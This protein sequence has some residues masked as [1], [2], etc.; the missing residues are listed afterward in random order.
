MADL[1]RI[2]QAVALHQAGRLAEAGP[3]YA[4]LL[5]S[6]PKDPQ[7]WYLYGALLT[8][9]SR[10]AEAVAP[11]ERA[12]GLRADY[13]EAWSA[14]ARCFNELRRY[15]EAE[16]ALRKVLR[17]QPRDLGAHCNLA[18]VLQTVG[19]YEASLKVYDEALAL[20]PGH[21]DAV[22]GK[23]E[24]LLTMGRYQESF[25]L[26]E[27]LVEGGTDHPEVVRVYAEAS[28]RM[29]CP[30]A[31]LEQARAVLA[32][33]DISE[34]HRRKLAFAAGRLADRL[35]HYDEAFG[36]FQ[37]GNRLDPNY[38]AEDTYLD[39][40]RRT[41]DWWDA[42]RHRSLPA[43]GIDSD[44]P[45]FIVGMPRSG[46]SLTEQVLDSH[47]QV[48]GAGELDDFGDLAFGLAWEIGLPFPEC[49]AKVT[50]RKLERLGKDHLKRLRGMN[51]KV[52]RVTDKMPHNFLYL[53]LIAR[54]FP[55]ARIVHCRR[56]ALD[57]CLSIYFQNFKAPHPFA[58]EL[59]A[60]GRHY[61]GYLDLMDH[62]RRVLDMPVFEVSYEAMVA[63]QETVSRDLVA[64]LGLPWDDACLRFHENKRVV[65]TASM[66]QVRNPVYNRSVE[67][68]RKY[69]SHLRPL[70]DVLE[71]SGRP[72]DL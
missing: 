11:L 55:G 37:Q 21:V 49:L 39:M 63:D 41:I 58:T 4:E 57:T 2:Q 33:S 56:G 46:T 10:F 42:D 43:T 48:H 69:E 28:V 64:Y 35:D 44:L 38:G 15:D 50:P 70:L 18:N 29:K 40:M 14:L 5:Q 30:E 47:P 71:S 36:Y 60:L 26:V 61:L 16:K 8:Q 25:D 13:A 17:A 34:A 27:P 31:G 19:R 3:L 7:L 51:R 65:D 32:R 72:V 22:S 52:L 45:V 12:V 59:A 20:Y 1:N 67:R 23:A 68:W 53:G 66:H 62:W 54:M 24:T 6:S 9:S